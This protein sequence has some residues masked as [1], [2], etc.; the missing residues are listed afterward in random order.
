M[1]KSHKGELYVSVDG[2]MNDRY[3][4]LIANDDNGWLTA[5]FLNHATADKPLK[6]YDQNEVLKSLVDTNHIEGIEQFDNTILN[7]NYFKKG[8]H[9]NNS[10]G[11][12]TMPTIISPEICCRSNFKIYSGYESCKEFRKGDNPAKLILGN[13]DIGRPTLEEAI[14]EGKWLPVISS[15]ALIYETPHDQMW[16]KAT[17][18]A[19]AFKK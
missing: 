12:R 15:R 10:Q 5:V 14:A 18:V 3:V 16:E 13:F 17:K 8:D 7:G 9:F 2:T 19:M 1:G 4:M 6:D 11:N